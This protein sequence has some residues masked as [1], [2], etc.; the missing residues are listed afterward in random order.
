MGT[1]E[2]RG[3]DGWGKLRGKYTDEKLRLF[4]FL[5]D[6]LKTAKFDLSVHP[7]REAHQ[8]AGI[9]MHYLYNHVVL[10]GKKF[11]VRFLVREDRKTRKLVYE[12]FEYSSH[13][14]SNN[15]IKQNIAGGAA[16]Y[17]GEKMLNMELV[18]CE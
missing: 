3:S 7:R 10:D 5:D 12:F 4:P 8:Q 9:M 18:P 11:E 6:L 13:G 17:T 2:F 15:R 14:M 1:I 16:L